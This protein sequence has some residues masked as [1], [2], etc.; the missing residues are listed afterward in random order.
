MANLTDLVPTGNQGSDDWFAAQGA[1]SGGGRVGITDPGQGPS[2]GL[3]VAG[4]AGGDPRAFIA[5]YQ[6]THPASQ[7]SPGE[8]VQALRAAGYNASP[9]MYGS[10]AS[11]N[12][13]SLPGY[14]DPDGKFKVIGG[15]GG[16]PFWYTGGDDSPGGG[17]GAAGGIGAGLENTP[18]FQFRL[19]EGLKALQ[20]SAA[21]R[22]TLLTGGTL[23]GLE[24]YAQDYA[25]N[26]YGNRVNQLMDLSRLGA[27]AA[28]QQATLGSTYA[29]QAGNILGGQAGNIGN[30]VTGQGNAAAAGTVAGANAWN[31]GLSNASNIAQQ[32]YLYNLMQGNRTPTTG[33]PRAGVTHGA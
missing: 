7:S 21:A 23:K 16:S 31:Q 32:Y 24:R 14:G 8:L 11:G 12:E 2:G 25:S 4:G 15:E 20:K 10:V 33:T 22:G 3:S 19:G 9:Y 28:G 5:E 27:G 6:R 1:P 13:I 29:G 17:G 26:E 30:M 18:G